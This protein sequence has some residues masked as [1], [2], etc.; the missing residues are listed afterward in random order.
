MSTLLKN[1]PIMKKTAADEALN[2][3]RTEAVKD[4]AEKP[5]PPT[6]PSIPQ[7]NSSY[8]GNKIRMSIMLDPS[9]KSLLEKI[10]DREHSSM[11]NILTRAIIEYNKNH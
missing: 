6:E 1:A 7:K 9:I 5:E 3:R 4:V 8:K 2:G 11:S 10:A